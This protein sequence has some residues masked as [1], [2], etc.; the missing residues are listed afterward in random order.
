M[1]NEENRQ[2]NGFGLTGHSNSRLSS[3]HLGNL[4]K[5]VLLQSKK[6]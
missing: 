4:N 6:I 3:Q 1:E 5:K 2:N